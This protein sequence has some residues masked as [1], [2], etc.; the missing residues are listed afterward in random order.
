MLHAVKKACKNAIFTIDLNQEECMGA[1]LS[2]LGEQTMCISVD[3]ISIPV[4]MSPD[5]AK[6]WDSCKQLEML[7]IWGATEATLRCIMGTPKP[8]ITHLSL[9]FPI[10]P[11]DTVDDP[12]NYNTYLEKSKALTRMHHKSKAKITGLLDYITRRCISLNQLAITCIDPCVC[13]FETIIH[14]NKS[15]QIVSVHFVRRFVT[16]SVFYEIG[17]LLSVFLKSPKLEALEFTNS[18]GFFMDPSV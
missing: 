12:R 11:P 5:T 7:E 16:G 10:Y 18:H 4:A 17:S 6:G 13:S 14:N 8:N 1:Q 2:I 9:Y 15:L 3:F